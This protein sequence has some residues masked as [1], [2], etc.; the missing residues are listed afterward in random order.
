[1]AYPAGSGDSAAPGFRA[2]IIQAHTASGTLLNTSAR[3]E[4]Q[5]A[6]T[7]ID[8]ASGQPFVNEASTVGAGADGYFIDADVINWS[9]N[10]QGVGAEI[11]SFRAPAK[12]DEPTPGIPGTDGINTDNVAG[13][14]LTFLELQA[15]AYTL[16]ANSDDG[17]LVASGADPI[18]ALRIPLGRFE[19]GR[20]AAD[21][22]F[23]FV[24]PVAGLYPFRVLWYEG[25]GD[26]NLEFFSVDPV[27][28]EKILVNDL[29][30]PKAIKAYR[31]VTAVARPFVTSISPTPNSL[32]VPVDSAI[33]LTLT[34]P[35]AQLITSSIQVALDGQNVPLTSVS[36][37]G[38]SVTVVADPAGNLTGT[39][40]YNVRVVFSSVGGSPVTNSFTFTTVRPP[41]TRPPLLQ[42]AAGLV[43]IVGRSWSL[44]KIGRKFYHGFS[45]SK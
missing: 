26:S 14:I 42:T 5:L 17:F 9:Q 40:L 36:S 20:G 34:N 6:G 29:T 19:G 2:R 21:T 18:D 43:V 30:N 37:A 33:Q 12:P 7:L 32:R 44:R 24:A 10:A 45:V 11:G 15:G 1:L 23:N 4:A 13:E 8:P 16:G 22:I 39:K 41:I 38:N 25:N 27:S 31:R 28:G 35:A 3:A